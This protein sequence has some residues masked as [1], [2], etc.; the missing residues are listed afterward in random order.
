MMARLYQCHIVIHNKHLVWKNIEGQY[1]LKLV[2]IVVIRQGKNNNLN[3]IF[4][5]K[6]AIVIS[7]KG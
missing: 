2:F 4:R 3:V 5:D 1:F 7:I 6:F